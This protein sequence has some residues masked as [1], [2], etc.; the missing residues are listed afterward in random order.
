MIS[1]EGWRQQDYFTCPLSSVIVS[2]VHSGQKFHLTQK[3][4]F[5]WEQSSLQEV[6]AQLLLN[7]HLF[8]SQYDLNPHRKRMLYFFARIL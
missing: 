8:W 7:I 4:H 2:P 6:F 3:K 5:G 1:E